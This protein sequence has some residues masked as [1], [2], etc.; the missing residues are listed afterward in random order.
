MNC[1]IVS[2]DEHH[3]VVLNKSQIFNIHC[4][5]NNINSKSE[6]AHEMNIETLL[7]FFAIQSYKKRRS[8]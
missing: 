6:R 8:R 3:Y 7:D 2:Q 4:N 5:L 1:V